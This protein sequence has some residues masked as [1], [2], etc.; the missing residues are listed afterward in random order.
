MPI[1]R[2]AAERIL[3]KNTGRKVMCGRV[4]FLGMEIRLNGLGGVSGEQERNR[5]PQEW[6]GAKVRSARST[7]GAQKNALLLKEKQGEKDG[8]KERAHEE[9]GGQKGTLK[10][11]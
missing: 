1:Y 6:G 3:K 2:A 10:T 11:S 7:M 4:D 5:R 8:K 9:K